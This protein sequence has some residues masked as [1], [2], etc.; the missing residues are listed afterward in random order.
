MEAA[1]L[2]KKLHKH[3]EIGIRG[4]LSWISARTPQTVFSVGKVPQELE[5]NF[6]EETSEALLSHKAGM[7]CRRPWDWWLG[8]RALC[9]L[10]VQAL[11][12]GLRFTLSGWTVALE[13][14]RASGQ[15]LELGLST[16]Q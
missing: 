2:I 4:F 9:C 8:C 16:V 14:G 3:Q 11:W 15:T 5:I 7:F 1:V 10:A 6:K 12:L 13:K